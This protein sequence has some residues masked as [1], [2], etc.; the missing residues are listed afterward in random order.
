[1]K[2]KIITEEIGTAAELLRR[3]GLVAVP[4]ETVYG[5]AG[6]GLDAAVIEKIYEV[7]GRPAVKPI[8]LMVSGSEAID[9]LCEDVPEAVKALTGRFWPGPLTI[10]L[11]AKPLVPEIL[12]AGGETVGLRCPRQEQTLALLQTLDFPLAVPSANPS[13]ESSPKNTEQVL[14]YFDGKIEAVID[15]GEC[16]L[17]LESTVADFSRTPYRILRQGSLPAE[18][19]MDALA[20]TMTIVGITGGSG[21]G[22]TT[23]LYEL[24]KRGALILD[25]DAVYHELLE[26]DKAMIAE[27]D[28][29]FTGTVSEGRV[30]RDLLS[31]IVFRDAEKLKKLNEITHRHVRAETN[32]RLREWAM[33]GGRLAALDAIELIS[34]GTADRCDFTLAVVA[35]DETRIRRIMARDGISRERA[36]LRIRAQRPNEYFEQNCDVTLH[37]DGDLEQFQ[38]QLNDVLEERLKHG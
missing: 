37:N 2:T 11:K 33:Q 6:C 4:T 32:R 36:E 28:A 16:E 35:S 24:E 14:L 27:L 23:A 17:G 22:K 29:A 7:K 30:R 13:G 21:C 5:L 12:R 18:K 3:G 31:E 19:L 10:V 8:S 1:M 15:G 25:C 20:D 34:S 38:K 9:G 26:G